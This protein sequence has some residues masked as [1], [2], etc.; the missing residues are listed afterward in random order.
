MRDTPP[1]DHTPL[2]EK[3]TWLPAQ[4]LPTHD[5]QK[6]TATIALFFLGAAIVSLASL[7]RVTI[8][9]SVI[10]TDDEYETPS[11]LLFGNYYRCIIVSVYTR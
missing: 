7:S 4:S 1:P 9:T 11:T 8:S 6:P 10:A 5:K 2:P 3:E